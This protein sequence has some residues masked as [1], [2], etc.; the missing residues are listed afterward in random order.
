MERECK[1]RKVDNWILKGIKI[2]F[3]EILMYNLLAFLFCLNLEK[4]SVEC[5]TTVKNL[6]PKCKSFF[7]L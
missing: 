1:Y 5:K 3:T 7:W 4:Y 2:R 6:E